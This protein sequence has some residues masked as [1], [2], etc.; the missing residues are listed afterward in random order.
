MK[1]VIR[2]YERNQ[3]EMP[4]ELVEIQNLW[5]GLANAYGDSGTC[6]LGAGFYFK[7]KGKDYKMLPISCW[8]GS[9]SWEFC[10]DTI[11]ALL[12]RIGCEDIC[13]EWGNMD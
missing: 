5:K 7:Y 1:E 11:Q 13:Y 12:K 9:I 8:Q 4:K 6:V 3:S 10:K 2:I